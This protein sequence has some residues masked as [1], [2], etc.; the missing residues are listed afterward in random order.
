MIDDPDYPSV[1]ELVANVAGEC[2]KSCS[3]DFDK[4][5]WL[6]DWILDHAD[7]DYTYSYCAAEGVLARGKGTCESYHRAYVMLL[8]KVGIPTG[9]I[10][11][12]GHV[13]TAAQLDGK[14][15]QID[16]TWDDM[17]AS[18]KG[19]FYE[20]LYF[21]LNDDIMKLVHSDH[22][23]P[24][25]GYECNSLEENYF[26][27]TGEIHQWSDLFAEKIRQKIAAGETSFT[28]PVNSD[29]PESVANVIYRLVAYELSSENWTNAT[30]SASYDKQKL[31]CSVTV[32]TPENNGGDNGNSGGGGSNDGNNGGNTGGG[33]G[34]NDSN[35]GGN[36][37]TD[38]ENSGNTGTT[39]TG[40]QRFASLLYENALGRSAEQSE[41][42]YWAQELTNGRTGAE[43]AYGFLF[44]EEFQNHNYNNA[45][46][47]EH[48]YLSLMGRASDTD[49]KAG[50]VKTLEN[51]ASRLYVFRQFINSEEFQQLCNTYEIQKGDVSLT[52]ERDQNYNVTCFVARNYTQFL[53]RNYDTDGLNH[54]CEAINHHTQSMQE[55]AYGFV[56]SAECT[57]KNLSNTEYVKMLY[58]GLMD[59]EG[60]NTGVT[61]WEERLNT[62]EASRE[63]I[64]WGFANSQEFTNLVRSYGL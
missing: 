6:H 28:L 39:L 62:G 16:S 4:A 10:A 26:I 19:T 45:D 27:K 58:R 17:G 53:S 13:W 29:L 37:G 23:Q 11:G 14:W 60:E 56:F 20:H 52:E 3:T 46:Y 44:S 57:N 8:N 9:R 24:V 1:E 54:W 2:E 22:T 41:L 48:L 7:Y 15:Y 25:A 40:K 49:G 5:V 34:S 51:G 43:V 64:F 59:R 42:D 47:V 30:L 31:T 32:K 61:Y 33:S 35:N 18:Y 63:Q 36:T 38:N 50:W 12:N 21:G 55:I